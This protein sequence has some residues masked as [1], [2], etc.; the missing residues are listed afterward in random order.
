M[1]NNLPNLK[2]PPQRTES[3]SGKERK[4]PQSGLRDGIIPTKITQV[5]RNPAPQGQSPK[6]IINELVCALAKP[7][8][9][10]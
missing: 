9:V 3:K 10:Y 8:K 1:L 7:I 5:T 4:K 2:I 6:L